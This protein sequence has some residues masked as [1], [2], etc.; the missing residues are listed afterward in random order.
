VHQ[1]SRN[2]AIV[3][4]E[5]LAKAEQIAERWQRAS[6]QQRYWVAKIG[7]EDPEVADRLQQLAMEQRQLALFAA[8]ARE[9]LFSPHPGRVGLA[10]AEEM[11]VVVSTLAA[12]R[13]MD[14]MR[15]ALAGRA[16]DE[17]AQ[18]A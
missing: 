4:R 15:L 10:D 13:T 18:A 7:V 2:R 3:Y 12:A 14:E 11:T 17:T 6:A 1:G 16:G 8:V 5:L 9:S